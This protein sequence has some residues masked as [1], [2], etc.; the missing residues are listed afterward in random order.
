MSEIRHSG[1]VLLLVGLALGVLAD[2]MLRA[3]PWGLNAAIVAST[4][5]AAVL[6]L[7]RRE[8]TPVGRRGAYIAAVFGAALLFLWRDAAVLKWMDAAVVAIGLCLLAS[9]RAGARGAR[10]LSGYFV[11]LAGTA[12]H[13]VVGAPALVVCDMPWRDLRIW[14]LVPVFV[15]V[16]RGAVLAVPIVTTFGLLLASADAIF[17]ARL[18]GLL[19][20]DVAW[21]FG[22][23]TGIAACGWIAAG[24][25]RAAVVRERPAQEVPPR[26][27][28]LVLSP[29]D[30][31][32]TLGLLDVLFAGF[33]WI[34]L[35]YLF[36]G[37]DWVQQIEGLT[38]SEYARRGF[39]ELVTVAVLVLGLLLIAQWLL[40]PA[41]ARLFAGL[42]GV[43]VA[44][45]FVML[46]SAVRRMRLYQ[47]EYGLTELRLYTTAFMLWLAMVLAWFLVTVLRG[48]REAFARGTLL[49]A[50]V[51]VVALHVADP[52]RRIVETNRRQAH[53]FD[54]SY[55]LGLSADA[56]P[57]LLETL[58]DL[59][60]ETRRTV[61]AGLLSRWS[62]ADS[63]DWRQWSLARAEAG[64]RIREYEAAL[65][66]FV[67]EGR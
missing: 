33:V 22:H 32:I 15:G 17:A 56:V 37:A 18:A 65:G 26:P 64:R 42:A 7:Q 55:A 52:Q 46:A 11:R 40:K 23:L 3:L 47:A 13:T 4:M 66:G 35:R 60:P 5:L 44:L 30:I 45:V 62:D 14:S 6:V 36:G 25:L 9:Q 2:T 24:F 39:F 10:T 34:Q 16:G 19:D 50:W 28:W 8:Q 57:A 21:L 38:Y 29:I 54:A 58:P 49:L 41:H 12:A 48:R 27:A 53:R 51:V 67:S 63:S 59:D 20:V 31:G 1:P 43:Q 61:A